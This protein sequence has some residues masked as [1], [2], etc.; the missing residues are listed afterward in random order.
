M[1]LVTGG[2]GFIGAHTTRALLDA[3][4]PVLPASRTA[5]TPPLLPPDLPTAA[6]DCTDPASLSALGARH[7][8]TTIVHLAAV[9][10]GR[11]TPLVELRRNIEGLAAVLQAATDWNSE[12]VIIAS[13]IGVYAGVET[14][15]WHE[16]APLPVASPHPIP[17]AK[18]AAEI[19]ALASGLN[20][21]TARIAGIWGP[22]GRPANPFLAA[23]RLVHRAAATL[24]PRI[25]EATAAAQAGSATTLRSPTAPDGAAGSAPLSDDGADMLYAPDCGAALALLAT[26]AVLPH[27]IYNI[28]AGRPTTNREVAEAIGRSVPAA[29][30]TLA[31]GRTTA[32]PIPYLDITRLRTDTGWSPQWPLHRAVPDYLAWLAAG[33]PR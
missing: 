1:I 32:D 23:P 7:R 22:L 6:L 21:V 18:K 19:M 28:G 31:E 12:R 27:R 20:V 13:S 4:A 10:L 24:P 29:R 17:A 5:T 8:I 25:T 3:G 30:P 14:L 16:D 11:E 33:H 15:P 9:G 2:L 26:T